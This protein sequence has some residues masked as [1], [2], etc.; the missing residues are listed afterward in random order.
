MCTEDIAKCIIPFHSLTGCDANSCFFGHGKMSLYDILSKSTESR[1]LI[2]KCGE[3]LS[4]S[5]DVLK[6]LSEYSSCNQVEKTKKEIFDVIASI[7]RTDSMSQ[8]IDVASPSI[9]FARVSRESCLLESLQDFTEMLMMLEPVI[10]KY[11]NIV[12]IHPHKTTAILQ[13]LSHQSL[14]GGWRI[15][16][17]KWYMPESELPKR[18]RKHSV[19]LRASI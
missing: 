9:A 17:A 10:R 8:I 6:F 3:C 1:N 13:N 14:E 15:F 4:L 19:I 5:V 2:S 12:Y 7:S 11:K 16:E 18:T